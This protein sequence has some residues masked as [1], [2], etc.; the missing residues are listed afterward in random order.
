MIVP[1]YLPHI[2][3]FLAALRINRDRLNGRSKIAMD[4]RLLRALLQALVARSPFDADFYRRAYPDIAEAHERG[5][6]P[7]LQQHFVETGFFEGRIGAPP[8][9]DEA[10]YQNTYKD[11]A[12]AVARGE[13]ASPREHYERSGAAEGRLPNATIKGEVDYWAS[14]LRDDSSRA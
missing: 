7:D 1:S 9:V 3:Q 13:I 11:V 5:D 6:I 2:D 14:I 12:R 4:V 10:F 8:E